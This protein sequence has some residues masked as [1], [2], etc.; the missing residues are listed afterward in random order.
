MRSA[1]T[2]S[3]FFSA[4]AARVARG[5]YP[6]ELQDVMVTMQPGWIIP[7]RPSRTAYLWYGSPRSIEKAR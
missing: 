1:S 4:A 7:P 5:R 2:P 6:Q 3:A